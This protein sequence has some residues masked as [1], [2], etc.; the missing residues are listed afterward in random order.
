MKYKCTITKTYEAEC[1]DGAAR[2]FADYLYKNSNHL[3]PE[4][5]ACRFEENQCPECGAGIDNIEW[6]DHDFPGGSGIV[7]NAVCNICG[8]KF[9]EWYEYAETIVDEIGTTS[10]S[11]NH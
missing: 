8:C 10:Q 2:E 11:T 6:M 4:I 5:S 7:H 1:E 9:Y 3:L